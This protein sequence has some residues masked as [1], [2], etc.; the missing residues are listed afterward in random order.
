LM[1]KHS[2]PRMAEHLAQHH[3]L[4][5]QYRSMTDGV[6]TNDLQAVARIRMVVYAWFTRHILGD[7]MD[8]ELGLFLQRIGIFLR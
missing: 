4:V 2:Y 3:E 5:A 6:K 1:R 8:K 7:R